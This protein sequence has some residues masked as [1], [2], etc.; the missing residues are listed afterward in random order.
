M[1]ILAFL[2][3]L[4]SSL[5]S[6]LQGGCATVL[7]GIGGGLSSEYGTR[8][9]REFFAAAGGASFL[10]FL[11]SFVGL[12]GGILAMIKKKSAF[13]VLLVSAGMCGLAFAISKGTFADAG[14]YGILYLASAICAKAGYNKVERE[15]LPKLQNMSSAPS[16]LENINMRLTALGLGILGILLNL[17]QGVFNN[18]PC[19]KSPASIGGEMNCAYLI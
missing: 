1:N 9:D 7:S 17:F 15:I 3:A 8:G 10:V 19:K 6:F 12:T 16:W 18:N 5:L 13:I 11:A 4:F 14:L 2:I